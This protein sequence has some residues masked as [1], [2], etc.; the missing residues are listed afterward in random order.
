MSYSAYSVLNDYGRD[1]VSILESAGV[2]VTLSSS[3]T[4]PNE[5]ELIS[6]V[7]QYDIL[8]IGAREKMTRRVYDAC[9]KTKIVGTLSVGVDH[10]CADFLDSDRVTVFNCPNSN[11]ISVA[12]H[13]L[14]LILA[15]KKRILEGYNSSVN[16]RGREGVSKKPRDLY[17]T[18]IG[19][20]GAGRIGTAVIRLANAFHM[21]IMCN[22]RNPNAHM[23]LLDLGVEFVELDKLLSQSDIITIHLPLN[24]QTQMLINKERINMMKKNAVFI[25]TSRADLVDIPSLMSKVFEYDSFFVGLDIDIEGYKEYFNEE[26]SNLIVTP[27][28]AGV[29]FDAILRMD[30]D[31]AKTIV[32]HL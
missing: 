21:R 12:E 24:S 25:N 27:H 26:R 2:N 14:A 16:G 4:R 9:T 15:L 13:T 32:D 22:T 29:S 31:L 18:T 23:D 30:S 20:I 8:I 7:Q 6:L 19:V 11:T 5:E 17:N 28:I 10:I 3:T 1:A